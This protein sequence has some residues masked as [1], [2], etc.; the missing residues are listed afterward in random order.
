MF[1]VGNDSVS[2]PWNVT[3]HVS[4][5]PEE[6]LL[7][8]SGL[9]AVKSG[10]MSTLKEANY[11]KHGDGTKVM[12]LSRVDQDNLWHTIGSDATG[13]DKFWEVNNQLLGDTDTLKSV[14]L[15]IVQRGGGAIMQLPVKPTKEDGTLTTL[16]DAL[17]LHRVAEGKKI[18][19][20]G[21][22]VPRDASLYEIQST[23]AN[24]DGWIYVSISK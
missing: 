6:D 3:V 21:V 16:A 17:A 23:L 22:D 2:V 5:F 8:L 7:R 12:G 1:C 14:A 10:F 20:Q 15:R 11:L 4:S 19:I 13:F 18:L 24:C 9:E